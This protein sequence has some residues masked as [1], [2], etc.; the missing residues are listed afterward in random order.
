MIGYQT[1][2]IP[3]AGQATFKGFYKYL[4]PPAKRNTDCNCLL[5]SPFP[6]EETSAEGDSCVLSFLHWED[7]ESISPILLHS[8]KSVL[9]SLLLPA[10]PWREENLGEI[11]PFDRIKIGEINMLDSGPGQQ[12]FDRTANCTSECGSSPRYRYRV[13]FNGFHW[14]SEQTREFA[15]RLAV[16]FKRLEDRRDIQKSEEKKFYELE[17][18]LTRKEEEINEMNASIADLKEDLEKEKS[19]KVGLIE[20][21]RK[22]KEARSAVEKLMEN[23]SEELDRVHQEALSASQQ[24]TYLQ[25]NAATAAESL[26]QM[27]KENRTLRGHSAL[28]QEQ[29]ASS[30]DT[31][32]SQKE[33]IRKLQYQLA[34]AKEKLE[35]CLGGAAKKLMFANVSPHPSSVSESICSLR[36]AARVVDACEIGVPR[37]RSH[38]PSM[39]LLPEL[40]PRFVFTEVFGETR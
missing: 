8:R 39:D 3:G 1:V 15:G 6:K 10:L 13:I 36:V 38:V 34:V 28:L 9:K 25:T 30:K 20:A 16:F 33:E 5:P 19:E 7:R 37:R 18:Q 27:Q 12:L 22:E 23:L 2:Y 17:V 35:A 4:P 31:C 24:I 40:W 14:K 11:P 32:N 29:L 21:N 26:S